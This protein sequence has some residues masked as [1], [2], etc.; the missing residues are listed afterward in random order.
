M[1]RA[2]RRVVEEEEEEEVEEGAE[3]RAPEGMAVQEEGVSQ[4]EE[5]YVPQQNL[6][7]LVR[8]LKLL[9]QGMRG[10]E[11]GE[12]YWPGGRCQCQLRRSAKG[13]ERRRTVCC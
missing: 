9:A 5:A 13:W 12:P 7:S 2:R 10:M 3:R 1:P 8:V 11:A 6:M 4:Q